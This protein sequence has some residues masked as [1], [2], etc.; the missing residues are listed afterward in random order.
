[1]FLFAYLTT[2][3]NKASDIILFKCRILSASENASSELG[4][5]NG[6]RNK[7]WRLQRSRED[8]QHAL[9]VHFAP[10][11][12]DRNFIIFFFY[13]TAV[14]FAKPFIIFNLC[15]LN[16]HMWLNV[17]ILIFDFRKCIKISLM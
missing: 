5:L 11:S 14:F 2:D 1:M 9:V 7:L 6:G 3:D 10:N 8:T 13:K 12:L 15:P 17:L 16:W 4:L